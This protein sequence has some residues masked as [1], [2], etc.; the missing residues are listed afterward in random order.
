[1]TATQTFAVIIVFT[2]L[3]FFI[4]YTIGMRAGRLAEAI[5]RLKEEG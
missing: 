1:M 5:R 4:G 3:S 2:I